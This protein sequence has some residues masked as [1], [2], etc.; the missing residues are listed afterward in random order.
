M[1]E[2]VSP[3]I[4]G[5]AIIRPK[6]V[7]NTIAL[8]TR[9]EVEQVIFWQRIMK[10]DLNDDKLYALDI[11]N[12]VPLSQPIVAQRFAAAEFRGMV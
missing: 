1:Q 4:F 2:T 5:L 9:A 8:L 12:V 7:Y 11:I 10:E 6:L 3:H